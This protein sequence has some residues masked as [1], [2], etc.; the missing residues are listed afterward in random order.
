MRQIAFALAL[1][2]LPHLTAGAARADAGFFP[3]GI[4]RPQRPWGPGAPPQSPPVVRLTVEVDPG[5]KATR[6]L[7]PR[8][9]LPALKTAALS[10]GHGDAEARAGFPLWAV[11]VSLSLAVVCCCL[12][13]TWPRRICAAACPLLVMMLLLTGREAA[14]AKQ[15]LPPLPN[16]ALTGQVVVEVVEEGSAVRLI[17][18]K[19]HAW[20]AHYGP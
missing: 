16:F 7:I 12:R 9:L 11:I 14:L 17:L 18:D 4:G 3:F 19:A 13:L 20:P 1:V 6:L 15:P 2:A 10:V 5:A 8:N